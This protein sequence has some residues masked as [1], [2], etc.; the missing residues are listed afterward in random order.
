MLYLYD[1]AIVEDLQNAIDPEGQMNSNVRAVDSASIMGI[2]AQLEEDKISFPLICVMR[3][4]NMT[5]DAARSNFSRL[6]C[7]HV[8]V[9]DPETNT[10]YLEKAIPVELNY[11]LHVLTTNTADMDELVREIL[12]RYSSM[13][14][15][16]IDKPY[17][18]TSKLRF[19]VAIPPG[20]ELRRE[21][22]NGEYI[23]QGKLYETIIPIQCDGAVLLDY[24][25][26]HMER[27]TTEM[28]VKTEY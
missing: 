18:A 21:S 14:F 8:E 12:F 6:H 24:T 28:K 26:K 1:N 4:E 27:L 5:I 3:D 25:P 9:I 17:E 16:T 7:G 13:Y 19:G 20:T 15:L 11:A 22:S 23:A 10:I 2:M